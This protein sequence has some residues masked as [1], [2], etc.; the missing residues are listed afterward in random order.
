MKKLTLIPLITTG[1]ILSSCAIVPARKNSSSSSQSSE[2]STNSTSEP[3]S[4]QP[5]SNVTSVDSS[6]STSQTYALTS[7]ENPGSSPTITS[8]PTSQNPGSSSENP[9]GSSISWSTIPSSEM[10]SSSSS[11]S[12]QTTSEIIHVDAVSLNF[13]E[14]ELEVGKSFKLIPTIYPDD[15]T[16]KSVI[17][18]VSD[19]SVASVS[20]GFVTA[21]KEG[22]TTVGVRTIDGD[23]TAYC[24]IKTFVDGGGDPFVPPTGD[25]ILSISEAGTYSLEKDYKQIYVN[26]PDDA[27]VEIKLNGHTIENSENSPI[28]VNSCKSIEIS[29]NG[30]STSYIKDK[31]PLFESEDSTQ[32]QGAIYVNDGDLTLK[33]S[34]TLELST[35]YY[36]GVHAKKDVE[37]K[38]LTLNVTAPN[39]A[40]KGKDSISVISG[41]LNLVCGGDG[42]HS[43]D[44][45]ISSKGNQRGNI[46][47]S[48]GTIS[49]DSFSDG[50][51]AAYNAVIEQSYDIT[52]TNITIKTN[53]YSSYK[54]ET[55]DPSKTTLYL[56]MNSTVYSSGNYTYAA[57]INDTWYKASYKG[58]KASSSSQGGWGGP[59]GGG[60]G[61]TTYYYYEL[62]KP[63]DATSF[64]LY[65]FSG[66]DVT[67]FSTTSY[68]AKSDATS[69]NTNYD[70]VTVTV[71]SN[72]ITLGSWS[73]YTT[74]NSR[75][76]NISAKGI[77]A[78][79]EVYIKG[80]TISIQAYDDGV[81]ANSD[82]V[83]ENG[84]SPLGNVHISGGSTTVYSTDDGIHADY[85][86]DVSDGD[87]NVTNAYEGIEGNVINISGGNSLV[88]ASD[89]GANASSGKSSPSI[90]I[91]GGYL[92]VQVPASG[93]TDGLD[94]NGTITMTGGVVIAAGPGSASGSGGGGSFAVDSESSAT[95]SGG[96]IIVF[97][98]FERTPSTSG[99]TRTLVSSS[100][101]SS[102]DHTITI[103]SKSYTTN[104]ISSTKGCIVYSDAGS[105]SLK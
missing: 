70:T 25:D 23:K 21:L 56:K 34:G 99:M 62:N 84:S 19:S 9:G 68:S 47:I 36:N 63:A 30:S 20:D 1:L 100:M 93:D 83:I 55:I 12:S 2:T 79:N 4:S 26:A 90:N 78:E 91:S 17:W 15:A 94:S 54:G 51:S 38:N 85:I 73:T 50:I 45:D 11:V 35:T 40:I 14:Y 46:N 5:S 105:S 86:L 69:F 37:I 10:P 104:L 42:L 32:G 29:A 49:I 76:A 59:G 18:G 81:H 6:I 44:S 22:N 3:S 41:T 7:S 60:G 52:P 48:G 80:G 39:H 67:E 71:S 16:N 53:K 65:R 66:K 95:L 33:G 72:R 61:S 27:K 74:G 82:G 87:I 101:V 77:K 103:G 75:T 64:T 89:D 58:S 98:G 31:R 24:S 97:G 57:Y 43:D 13:D 96:T 28:Y 92:D 8:I 88:R 102:G